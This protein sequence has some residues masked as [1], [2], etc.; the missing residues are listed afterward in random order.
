LART[1]WQLKSLII[2]TNYD[3]VLHWASSQQS[4]LALLDNDATVE[5]TRLLRS[6]SDRPGIWHLHGRIDNASNLILTPD[7][8]SRLYPVNGNTKHHYEAAL[9]TLRSLL[10]TH[11][12]LFIGFSM[13]DEHFGMQLRGVHDIFEG[14]TGPH[15]VLIREANRKDL[16]ALKLP[17]VEPIIFSDYGVPLLQCVRE[18]AAIAQDNKSASIAT[19]EPI[20]SSIDFSAITPADFSSEKTVFYVPFARKG[21]QVLGR[22]QAMKDVRQQLL[23]GRRTSIGQTASFQGLGGLGKTQLA[24]EYA[25]EHRDKYPNGVIWISADQEIDSQLIRIADDARWI[26]PQS[27]HK[28]KLTIALHRLRSYSDCL[29][30]FDN[31][32]TQEAIENYFPLP[33]ACPHILITSRTEQPGFIPIKIDSLD[34]TISLQLLIQEAGRAPLG[35]EEK[36]AANKI[37]EALDGLP[38]ALELAG[39]YLRNRD[40]SWKDYWNL[41]EKN[42]KAA[43]PARFSQASFTKHEAD[44]YSTLRISQEVFQDEP[45]LKP[46]LDLLTWSG[47]SQMGRELIWAA[48]DMQDA[49]ELTGALGL[50]AKLGLLKKSSEGKTYSLHRLVR[51]VRREETPIKQEADWAQKVCQH[52]GNW[53][54]RLREDFASLSKFEE[55]LEHLI[56]WAKNAEYFSHN[57]A[58]RLTW[59]QA[60][61]SYHRGNY[62]KISAIIQKALDLYEKSGIKK[63]VL[64]AHL[65]NDMGFCLNGLG[66]HDQAL[67]YQE[68]S[69]T[70]RLNTKGKEHTDTARSYN[71]AGTS[72]AALD[73][74]YKALEY[75]HKS[76]NIYLKAKGVDDSDTARAYDN[77]GRTYSQL[78]EYVKSLIVSQISLSIRL[79][80]NGDKHPDIAN[81]YS[82]LGGAYSG[83][84][85]HGEA[86]KQQEKAL[87][88]RLE[89]FGEEHPDTAQSYNEIGVSHDC[90]EQY[91]KACGFFKKA[92]TIRQNKLGKHHPATIITALNYATTLAK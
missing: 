54:E 63:Q 59:L 16:A 85:R 88:I 15:Y 41:L 67:A 61:P 45:Q 38:L 62:E 42:L 33:T 31:V 1:I 27:E 32:E 52:V 73:Q 46:I 65:Y 6:E 55:E 23:T 53:F 56:E 10:A 29:I 9:T 21:D 60:Y 28:D 79:K 3:R 34:A 70:I 48:L 26:A 43:L 8:Y 90:N 71:N 72:Y 84:S 86:I 17:N 80:I 2:T 92:L 87:V 22:D 83:L 19:A 24:I 57:E 77:I 35:E 39:A 68:K 82:T 36:E 12:F 64:L 74:Q 50:G 25:Y 75:Y 47:A 81:S 30:I 14:A 51:R 49:T 18:L 76:L 66:K 69:L 40:V 13:D 20:T 4:D 89:L 11:T 7:G 78:K 58:C 44:L 37:V 5:F 91:T